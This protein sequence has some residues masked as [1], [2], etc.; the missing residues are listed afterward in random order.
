MFTAATVLQAHT[1]SHVDCYNKSFKI[2][3]LIFSCDTYL[4]FVVAEPSRKQ[5]L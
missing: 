4:S 1:T 5:S 2:V 3:S